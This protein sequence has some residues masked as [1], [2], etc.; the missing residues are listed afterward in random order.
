MRQLLFLF[1]AAALAAGQTLDP[2]HSPVTLANTIQDKNFYVLSLLARDASV[3]KILSTDPALSKVTQRK[4][5]ELENTA[6]RCEDCLNI[7]RFNDEEVSTISDRLRQLYKTN[8]ELRALVNGPLI[9]SGMYVRY[10]SKPGA[11]LLVQ[12]GLDALQGVN[13]LIEV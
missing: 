8:A 3:A 6:Q 9:Q 4:R 13:R 2:V 11:D 1:V 5:A 7:I 12:A 10:H